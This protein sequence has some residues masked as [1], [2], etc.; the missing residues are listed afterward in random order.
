MDTDREEKERRRKEKVAFP[1]GGGEA[2]NPEIWKLYMHP[3]G[4]GVRKK[5]TTYLSHPG[6]ELLSIGN[7]FTPTH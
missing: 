2:T 4:H 1:T 6:R 5:T 3:Y 7:L